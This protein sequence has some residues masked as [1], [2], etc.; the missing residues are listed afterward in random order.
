VLPTPI[1]EHTS[2]ATV[3][4]S[5][6]AVKEHRPVVQVWRGSCTTE[7]QN[8]RARAAVAVTLLDRAV[9]TDLDDDMEAVMQRRR[10][11]VAGASG[12]AGRHVVDVLEERGHEVVAMSRST[13]VDVVTGAGLAEAL[14]GVE[15]IV[16]VATGPSPEQAAATAFFAASARN[17][18][19]EGQR[20]GVG[21]IVVA[22]I[23]GTDRFAGGYGAAKLAHER[24]LLDGP[25]P[26]VV[27]RATQFHELVGQLMDWG[28]RGD[29]VQVPKMRT[30]PVAARTVAEAL[31]ELAT[32]PELGPQ[33]SE[34][35]GPR[36]ESLVELATLL[37]ARRGDPARVEA[38]SSGPDAELNEGGA[39]LPGPAATLAGPT[40][41]DWLEVTVA[42]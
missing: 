2:S 35:A 40:F 31:V 23:V 38:V 28:R 42:A 15:A 4:G 25:I 22:S 13:G 37:A 29:V 6:F 26:A 27:L 34:L 3:S 41:A 21:R 9:S 8:A 14:E 39:L 33:L 5:R 20:A 10:I 18:Q 30:Q 36:E 12:R 11:A 1:R 16:D 7:G 19:Q 24:A 32:S 17:L